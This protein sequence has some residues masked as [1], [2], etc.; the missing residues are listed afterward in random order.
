MSIPRPSRSRPPG[1]GLGFLSGIKSLKG[2]KLYSPS[3]VPIAIK[4]GEFLVFL[5]LMYLSH[6]EATTTLGKE[7][8]DL[9]LLCLATLLVGVTLVAPGKSR[10]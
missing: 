5:A 8:A 3:R 10:D 2:S 1:G 4:T 7:V 9:M 6:R